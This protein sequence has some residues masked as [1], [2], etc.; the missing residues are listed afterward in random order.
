MLEYSCLTMLCLPFDV[1]SKAIQL[2]THIYSLFF[3]P[4]SCLGYYR[5]LSRV[6]P[7]WFSILN[8]AVC[9]VPACRSVLPFP[10]FLPVTV[11]SFSKSVAVS[12]L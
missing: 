7:R 10:L 6:G 1:F 12:A 11:N 4:I 8:A 9:A 3:K 2:H 5:V